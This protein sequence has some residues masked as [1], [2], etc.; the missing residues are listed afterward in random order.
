MTS[1]EE[2]FAS[3]RAALPAGA[4]LP[5]EPELPRLRPERGLQ[6]LE[7]FVAAAEASGARVHHRIDPD[8]IVAGRGPDEVG[9]S[10]AAYGLA[11]TGSIVLLSAPGEPRARS[12]LPPVH[13][14]TVAVGTILPGLP[15]LFA[16]LPASLPSSVAIVTGPS[17]SADIE[18]ILAVGV[19]G[20]RE[21]HVIVV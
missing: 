21:V 20:P 3:L 15:E 9:V 11:D 5:P 1:R 16:A 17:R 8:V 12:L 14:S 7:R 18:Q 2:F 4:E 10:M 19:H 13:V 6:L